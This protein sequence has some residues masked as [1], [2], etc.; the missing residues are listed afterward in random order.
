[1]S[2]IFNKLCFF[3]DELGAFQLAYFDVQ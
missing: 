1:L 2:H 3:N